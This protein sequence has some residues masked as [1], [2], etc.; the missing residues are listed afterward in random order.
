[1]GEERSEN[2]DNLYRFLVDPMVV[3]V[4]V[5]VVDGE[6][7]KPNQTEGGLLLLGVLLRT[8]VCTTVLPRF[9]YPSAG[10]AYS[11]RAAQHGTAG[12]IG[13]HMRQTRLVSPRL[14]PEAGA[15][16]AADRGGGRGV[17]MAPRKP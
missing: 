12:G 2:R 3:V 11:T 15:L 1:M 4:V 13:I 6:D 10:V 5:V 7:G 16:F 8:L 17:D 14:L 9:T